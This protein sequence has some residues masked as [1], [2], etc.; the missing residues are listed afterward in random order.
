VK[1]I[2]LKKIIEG[3]ALEVK[4][5]APQLF[6]GA[7]FPAMAL[8]R[9]VKGDAVLNADQIA[10]LCIV[11]GLTA[12][13]LYD[14]PNWWKGKDLKPGELALENGEF[15]AKLN[16]EKWI[17]TIEHKGSLFFNEVLCSKTT[18]LSEFIEMLNNQVLIFKNQL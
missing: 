13:E 18:P 5:L 3:E 10:K 11:T 7:K 4:E 6:P 12:S 9:I 8:N 14:Y 2:D 15:T 16:L 1:K 17:V